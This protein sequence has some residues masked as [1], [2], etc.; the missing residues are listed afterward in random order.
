M[1]L[2]VSSL[3]IAFAILCGS[4]PVRAEDFDECIEG[5]QRYQAYLP[6]LQQARAQCQTRSDQIRADPTLSDDDKEYQLQS[7][8]P[9]KQTVCAYIRP[10]EGHAACE[11]YLQYGGGQ[12]NDYTVANQANAIL[13]ALY[14]ECTAQ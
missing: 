1:R 4:S 13:K 6:S 2:F 10:E 12:D 8:C 14:D 5:Q 9:M 11:S 3:A 7:P